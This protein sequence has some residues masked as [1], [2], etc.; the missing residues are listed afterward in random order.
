M[1]R[2]NYKDSGVDISAGNQFVQNIE[3]FVRKTW[4][5]QVISNYGGFSGLFSLD[6]PN[7]PL[8]ASNIKKPILV[9]CADGVGTKLKIAHMMKN[10]TPVGIDLVA[11]NVND[12]IVC[13][14]TPLFFLDYIATSKLDQDILVQ[15]IKGISHGCIEAGCALLGG[16]TA[17][18]PGFYKNGEYDIAGFSVGIVEN[19]KIITGERIRPKDIVLGIGSSGL[20]SNG[21]SLVRKILFDYKSLKVDTYIPELNDILGNV[22][23]TPTRIYVKSVLGILSRYKVKRVITGI[24]HITGG[25]LTDN[26]SR[27][28]PE[29]VGIVINTKAWEIPLIFDFIQR[30]GKVDPYEMFRVFNMGIGM[31]IIV[32]PYYADRVKVELEKLGE[33]VWKIGYVTGK[34]KKKIEIK[35]IG[36]N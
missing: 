13:G 12:L 7:L 1:K 29:G 6:L 2:F 3:H 10:H 23:L 35:N 33:R 9:A 31:V 26:I 20:H 15:V 30:M 17:E 28:L 34:V 32:R 16:E 11:M 14:A 4:G 25:G 18:M 8:F 19:Y 36:R 27:I 24:A 5:P 21:F 22:L